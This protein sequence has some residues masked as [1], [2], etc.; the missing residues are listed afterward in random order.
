MY[1]RLHPAATGLNGYHAALCIVCRYYSAGFLSDNMPSY[2]FVGI[3]PRGV[4]SIASSTS[5]L[6][7]QKRPFADIRKRFILRRC[8][9]HSNA[10]C[11]LWKC[12]GAIRRRV[13][14]FC[15]SKNPL[16]LMAI[17]CR[18]DWT[19]SELFFSTNSIKTTK[20]VCY[21]IHK[22]RH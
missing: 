11:V 13:D 14:H 12:P 15:R 21:S 3:Q 18:R 16:R 10:L 20:G 1:S 8:G 9:V 22:F 4:L 5:I 6:A 19:Q 2:A 17:S 7:I